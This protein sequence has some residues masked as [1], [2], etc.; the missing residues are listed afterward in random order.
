[1]CRRTWST[2]FSSN[3][4]QQYLK[5][6]LMVSFLHAV[7]S[8]GLRGMLSPH[9]CLSCSL[10]RERALRCVRSAARGDVF[11]KYLNQVKHGV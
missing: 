8:R 6:S 10:C 9:A 1:M 2:K 5:D 3:G 7:T 4:Y 11:Y